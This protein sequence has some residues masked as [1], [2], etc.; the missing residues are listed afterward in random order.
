MAQ[1]EASKKTRFQKG[2]GGRPKG[3]ISKKTQI[4]KTLAQI[5]SIDDIKRE[6]SEQDLS[7]LIADIRKLKLKDRVISRLAI[8]EY[9]FPKLGRQEVVISHEQQVVNVFGSVESVTN[10]KLLKENI[11]DIDDITHEIIE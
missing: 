8:M 6:Y 9:L 2:S 3:A 7:E 1:A 4:V 11:T 10:N 5:A